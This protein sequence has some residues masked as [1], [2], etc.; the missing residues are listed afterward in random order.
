VP[1]DLE[2]ALEGFLGS[3][4]GPIRMATAR[5]IAREALDA[6]RDGRISTAQAVRALGEARDS[7]RCFVRPAGVRRSDVAP[8]GR[9]RT[10][11]SRGSMPAGGTI[12]AAAAVRNN[13]KD[14]GEMRC[15]CGAIHDHLLPAGVQEVDDRE[16]LELGTCP[17]CGTTLCVR[18]WTLSSSAK[19]RASIPPSREA[20]S[21]SS[22]PVATV[23]RVSG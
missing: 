17:A 11:G 2:D 18:Q 9:T 5:Y 1:L 16:Y 6:W 3:G 8:P 4:A 22:I 20:R 13:E 10:D 19:W 23:P 7:I 15:T 21:S 12:D 14:M